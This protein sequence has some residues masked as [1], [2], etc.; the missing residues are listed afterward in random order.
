MVRDYAV[1]QASHCNDLMIF[2]NENT[3]NKLVMSFDTYVN[4]L[5]G[6]LQQVYSFL[7]IPVTA[8]LLSKAA[9]LQKTTHDRTKRRASYDPKYN[10]TLSSLG[11]DEE[12]V[13]EYFSDYIN[14][15]KRLE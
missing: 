13:E 15:K 2:Y 5:A 12:K 11:I 6:T 1:S 3:K 4:N 7:N 14:W 9:V 8:E 10:R